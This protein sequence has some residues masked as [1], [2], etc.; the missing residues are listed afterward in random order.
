MFAKRSQEPGEG[1]MHTNHGCKDKVEQRKRRL[2]AK[3]EPK[4]CSNMVIGAN[5]LGEKEVLVGK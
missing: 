1:G 2:E 4:N 3:T 5:K